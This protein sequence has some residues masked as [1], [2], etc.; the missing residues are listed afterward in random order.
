MGGTRQRQAGGGSGRALLIA[1]PNGGGRWKMRA[2]GEG[3][4]HDSEAAEAEAC[5]SSDGGGKAGGSA[6]HCKGW[7]LGRISLCGFALLFGRGF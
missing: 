2:R 4:C 3:A 1:N 7:K 6:R 5:G